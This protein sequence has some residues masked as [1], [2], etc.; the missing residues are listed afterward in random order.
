MLKFNVNKRDLNSKGRLGEFTTPHGIVSTPVFMPVGTCATVKA[1]TVDDIKE[2]GASV[3]LANTYHLNLRPGSDT[4]KRA[5]G[6]HKFMN[7]PG[8]ILTDSGGFQVFSLGGLRK[9]SEDGV[10]FQSH[11]DGSYL[12]ISPERAIEIQ[13]ELG[14]DI[15]VCFDECTP[16]PATYE[17][18]KK[19]MELTHR[20]AK[21]C[22][23]H[24]RRD[25]QA[26]FGIVQ[27]GMYKELREI[28]AKEVVDIGFD[29]YAIG[30]LS[31]GETKEMMQE[32][33]EAVVEHLPEDN[34][35]Y[36]M[37]VGTPL[38]LVEGVLRGIDM[39][40]C[41]MPT[42]NARNGSLFTSKGKVV[43]KNARYADDFSSLDENCSCKTCKGYSKAYLR[44][45]FMAKEILGSTLNTIHNLTYYANIIKR[46]KAAISSDSLM[47][48]REEIYN[49]CMMNDDN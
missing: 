7:Y 35:R 26:L 19:S 49:E 24:K 46:I 12:F 10:K 42:R 11:V 17:Y 29:G 37:G 25:D 32:M 27:G 6:L 33:T 48:L 23:D 5:G 20:W 34:P 31:V 18:T 47:E 45:I 44:H 43:I 22:K 2:T 39:F 21:R 14:A 1:V 13:E 40:D 36:L 8:P 4:V 28:S 9:I 41:V 16:Y 15:I 30:G 3:I 38:D